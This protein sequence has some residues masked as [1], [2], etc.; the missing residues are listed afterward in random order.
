MLPTEF[1]LAHDSG[2]AAIL[3]QAPTEKIASGKPS[4]VTP[5]I[6]CFD[7]DL[8]HSENLRVMLRC[9]ATVAFW[10]QG[11]EPRIYHKNLTHHSSLVMMGWSGLYKKLN[12][13]KYGNGNFAR[14]EPSN[15]K[16]G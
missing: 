11:A 12:E 6:A 1:Y 14:N 10:P 3:W 5:Q 13:N 15:R 9:W 4:V 16:N 2:E 7:V 8:K